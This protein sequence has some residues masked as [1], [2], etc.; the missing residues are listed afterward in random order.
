MFSILGKILWGH[1]EQS[2]WTTQYSIWILPNRTT[3]SRSFFF[4][5]PTRDFLSF[6]K[7]CPKQ[8]LVIS[9][10]LED[11]ESLR[12]NPP[13]LYPCPSIF[14]TK[15]VYADKEVLLLDSKIK[16][17]TFKYLQAKIFCLLKAACGMK[18]ACLALRPWLCTTPW[19]L[20]SR[21]CASH[22]QYSTCSRP[23]MQ[24][25]RHHFV[26]LY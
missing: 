4:E 2:S 3:S 10:F 22:S 13:F 18:I 11:F 23:S 6:P 19:T 25:P 8:C 1:W 15:L 16:I 26:T 21:N 7:L 24:F 17:S 20:V 14:S 5:L 9:S 12:L